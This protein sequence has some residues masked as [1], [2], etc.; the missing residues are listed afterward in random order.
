MLQNEY[1]LK[2]TLSFVEIMKNDI[3]H[4]DKEYMSYD[5]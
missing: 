2:D 1:L 5:I 3:L 4:P